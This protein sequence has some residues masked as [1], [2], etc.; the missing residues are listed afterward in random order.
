MN[1]LGVH[2]VVLSAL[3]AACGSKSQSQTT[4]GGGSGDTAGSAVAVLPDVPFEQLDHDQQIQFM[5]EKVVPTMGPLF[6]E[7]D[8]EEFA[9]FGCKTCHGPGA[10]QGEFD[11][12]AAHLPKL[13]FGDMSK[14]DP[15]TVE[16]MGK[17]VKPTMAKLLGEAEYSPENPKGFG[18]LQC[19][20]AEGQ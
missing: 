12:P 5:K 6:K 9:E 4:P 16:W 20:T 10:E 19:H 7:H 14:F 2:L 13:N 18:C 11:M 3:L 17:V 8:A 1:R 15:K